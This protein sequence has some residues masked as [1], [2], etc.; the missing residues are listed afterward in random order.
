VLCRRCRDLAFR[1]ARLLRGGGARG[2]RG[3][4]RRPSRAGGLGT[5]VVGGLGRGGGGLAVSV[6]GG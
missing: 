3:R 4:A 6:G 5:C 1:G 2:G